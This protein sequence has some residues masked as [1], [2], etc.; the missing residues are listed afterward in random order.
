MKLK[1]YLRGLAIGIL[2]S[3]IVY[4]VTSFGDKATLS[5]AEIIKRAQALGMVMQEDT[6][7]ESS[8]LE[9]SDAEL[10]SNTDQSSESEDNSSGEDS[11]EASSSNTKTPEQES[12]NQKNSEDTSTENSIEI[13][14][15]EQNSSQDGSV[16]ND[17]AEKIS[18]VIE[19]GMSAKQIVAILKDN[20]IIEDTGA[21]YEYL[22]MY[23]YSTVMQPG[24]YTVQ[25]GISYER[26]AKLITHTK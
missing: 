26:L 15:N 23:S 12:S 7:F 13:P 20:G 21:F 17:Q 6:L 4:A 16:S 19:P 11:K 1:F 9:S 8:N 25:K 22:Q 2:F 10:P 3:T 5:N 18:F 24:N 14:I